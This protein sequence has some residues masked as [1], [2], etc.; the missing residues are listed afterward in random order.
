M[1][2]QSCEI[3]CGTKSW[4]TLRF[5]WSVPH[6][7]LKSG[8][9]LSR[10]INTWL[11]LSFSSP[12]FIPVCMTNC[13]T[14]IVTVG[15]PA[16]GKTYISKKLTRYLNWI[17][18]PTRGTASLRTVSSSHWCLI[19]FIETRHINSRGQREMILGYVS[20]VSRLRERWSQ[21][22]LPMSFP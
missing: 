11:E 1:H 17:G 8:L 16:R 15:L 18:V 7:T 14:L 20:R 12:S 13:P 9:H 22:S 10:V 5:Y 19:N 21:V 4:D 2:I 3:N 6:S